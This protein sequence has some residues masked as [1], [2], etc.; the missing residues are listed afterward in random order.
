[1]EQKLRIAVFGAGYVGLV[2]AACLAEIGHDVRCVD[3]DR[4]KVTR[5]QRGEIPFHEPGLDEIVA[6]QISNRRLHFTADIAVAL[7]EV[8]VILIAVGTPLRVRDGEA[9]LTY[10]LQAVSDAVCGAKRAI[11]IVTKSTVPVGTGDLIESRASLL[12]PGLTVS[13]VS[14]PEFLREGSAV[15]D[16]RKPD[17]I[18]VGV[19]SVEAAAVMREMYAAQ[20]AEG[21]PYVETSRRTAEMIKYAAN[22]FLA[23]K[24]AFANEMADLCEMIGSDIEVVTKAMGLDKRIGD[25][26]LKAG[27]GYGGSCF[28]K[29][30]LAL[31]RTAQDHGVN[32]RIVRETVVTNE[33]RKR[34]LGRR[35]SDL[36]GGDLHGKTVAIL[37]LAF[38]A[39]TDDVRD[40]PAIPLIE[41]LQ[42]SGARIKAYDPHAM[43]NAACIFEDVEYCR[44]AM[45]CMQDAH[46]AV[47]V[48]DW[49][50]FRQLDLTA[51]AGMMRQRIIVDFRGV[52]DSNEAIRNGFVCSFVGRPQPEPRNPQANRARPV[53]ATEEL[54]IS[55]ER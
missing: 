55:Q 5:L 3:V 33:S 12:R 47:V 9:D 4:A 16:F 17:R 32:L 10:V 18:V 48:T 36:V 6:S 27:P 38:K 22:A 19:N 37:G 28:P 54:V 25:Q 49:D 26:F 8:D 1:L 50:E 44:S 46:A 21:V 41:Y 53:V 13:V 24:I 15:S 51:V 35:V 30:T 7:A 20:I 29:D 45:E 43:R 34:N 31:L 23:T 52:V 40:S 2:S 42:R 39:N 14:N 11:T